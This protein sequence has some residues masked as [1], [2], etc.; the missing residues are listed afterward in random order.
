MKHT[1]K[2]ISRIALI[3]MAFA[4]TFTGLPMLTGG[5]TSYAAN[6]IGTPIIRNTVANSAKK[7]NDVIWDS[8]SVTGANAYEL[9]WKHK[10]STNWM[11]RT[12]GNVNR[13][14][15]SGLSI[16]GLYEA[17]VRPLNR[18]GGKTS[19]GNWS[20]TVYRYFHT[21]QKIRLVSNSVGSFTMSWQKNPQA[22]SYQVMYSEYSNGAG[23]A[24]TISSVGPNTTSFTKAGLTPGK[25]YYV[26][27]R[28]V[29]SI[30]K[31]NYIGNISCP[32]AVK[33]KGTAPA[34]P[35]PAKVTGL[36]CVA[37]TYNSATIQWTKQSNNVT[38]Y[39]I[40]RD[41]KYIGVVSKNTNKFKNTGLAS[42]KKYTYTVRAYL[43]SGTS[44]KY[45]TT[46]SQLSVTTAAKPVTKDNLFANSSL[47]NVTLDLANKPRTD[48]GVNT[49]AFSLNSKGKITWTSSNKSV[50]TVT[51]YY[52]GTEGGLKLKAAG[53][54]TITATNYDGQKK[55]CTVTVKNSA[56]T[57]SY[58]AWT[59]TKAATTSTTGTKKRTCSCGASQTETI[60]KITP[61]THTHSWSAWTVIKAATTTAEGT[62]K[63]TC[64]CG[65]SETQAIPKL[66][67]PPAH[68]YNNFAI[69]GS[70]PTELLYNESE[71]VYVT[72]PASDFSTTWKSS[73]AAV[74]AT[75]NSDG[76][77]TVKALKAFGSATITGTLVEPSGSQYTGTKTVSFKVSRIGVSMRYG[78]AFAN[79]GVFE[80][81]RG[82]SLELT[83]GGVDTTFSD[84]SLYFPSGSVFSANA[85]DLVKKVQY[86]GCSVYSQDGYNLGGSRLI[87][88]ISDKSVIMYVGDANS[89]DADGSGAFFL[90]GGS[91]DVT[92]N[93]GKT[94]TFNVTGRNKDMITYRNF[95]KAFVDANAGKGQRDIVQAAL[96]TVIA[97]KYGGCKQAMEMVAYPSEG[98]NCFAKAA[99]MQR[100]LTELGV[101]SYRHLSFYNDGGRHM[102]LEVLIG[103][104]IL[105][106]DPTNEI[107]LLSWDEYENLHN[108]RI[109][110][111]RVVTYIPPTIVY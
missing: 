81:S 111:N 26:Q 42:K 3:V 6:P 79:N 13:G 16:G 49:Y 47:N 17:K 86:E 95:V 29:R 96:D 7:T 24:N 109:N 97:L 66:D 67:P 91:T 32:V 93:N 11:S 4:I 25:T 107:W 34:T 43:K 99:L 45:G 36:K 37:K 68:T 98:G 82:S 64:S 22:T 35:T 41:G 28:E 40:Y 31:I 104:E 87:T 54:T 70:S 30:G 73:N 12:V 55:T 83:V 105:I 106:S 89:E 52:D 15:T 8:S 48:R 92:Y 78:D 65:A 46:S 72:L 5:F 44:Y 14:V 85:S 69:S 33:L 10:N 21:T 53:K 19:Y 108:A 56:H 76:S 38:G 27:V 75:G 90:G 18:S 101:E 51:G 61:T 88:G 100:L 9:A 2:T 23:A 80:I 20:K 39:A 74:S 50:A 1:K 58:G 57:H 103:N 110:K 59:V 84:L 63:R 94:F 62:K 77:V 71:T 102:V 60:P